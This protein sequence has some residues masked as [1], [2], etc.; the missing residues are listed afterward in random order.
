MDRNGMVVDEGSH[1]Q[2]IKGCV[3]LLS[4]G[5]GDAHERVIAQPSFG[6]DAAGARN[7]IQ[8]VLRQQRDQQVS[9]RLDMQVLRQRRE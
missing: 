8:K 2:W 6:V 7:E 4:I 1:Y 5:S 9:R 3:P